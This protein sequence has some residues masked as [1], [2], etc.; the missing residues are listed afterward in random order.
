MYRQELKKFVENEI[1]PY[2]YF[3]VKYFEA[4]IEF[5]HN[6]HFH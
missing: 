3:G 4:H 2:I 5:F 6:T 1:K